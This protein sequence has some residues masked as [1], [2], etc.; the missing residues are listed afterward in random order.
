MECQ[1]RTK[2]SA[3]EFSSATYTVDEAHTIIGKDKIC[4]VSFYAAISR[5]EVPSVRL[6]KRIL[7]PRGAFMEWLNSSWVAS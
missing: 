5:R 2:L 1:E 6:G 7:I 3:T 4:R